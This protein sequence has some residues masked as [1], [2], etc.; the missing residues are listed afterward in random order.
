V[1]GVLL[2]LAGCGGTV[3]ERPLPEPRAAEPQRRDLAWRESYPGPG[4]ERIVFA[5]ERFEVTPAGW[6]ARVAVTNRTSVTFDARTRNPAEARY[7]LML[8][9]T[10]DLG[11]LEQANE[12]GSLPPVRRATEIEPLPPPSLAPGA[13][14]RAT[15]SARGTLPAGAHVR[16]VFGVLRARGEPPDGME[17]LLTWITDRSYRLRP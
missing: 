10:G 11:E 13:T 15:L 1:L 9:A 2:V 14:W 3:E 6:N 7:G 17:R 5:V 16:L 12:R 8:F 4:G